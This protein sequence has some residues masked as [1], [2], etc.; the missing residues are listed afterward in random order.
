[1]SQLFNIGYL[2]VS[3]I[4]NGSISAAYTQKLASFGTLRGHLGLTANRLLFYLSRD[5]LDENG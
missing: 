2:I 5:N 1:V 3:G 4:P